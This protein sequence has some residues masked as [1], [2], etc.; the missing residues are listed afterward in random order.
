MVV[1]GGSLAA[2]IHLK[3]IPSSRVDRRRS[4]WRNDLR[5]PSL[6]GTPSRWPVLNLDPPNGYSWVSG[7]FL[8]VCLRWRR[9]EAGRS[10]RLFPA[11]L[12]LCP[13]GLVVR[14]LLGV[15]GRPRRIGRPTP[16]FGV[17]ED[18]GD[19]RETSRNPHPADAL[20]CG[21]R[22]CRRHSRPPGR[23][24][25]HPGRR[26]A[27]AGCVPRHGPTPPGSIR[28]GASPTPSAIW[29]R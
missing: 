13:L 18:H 9:D 4:R 26:R 19:G 28:P 3:Q 27:R 11:V 10:A 17:V 12:R 2:R 15:V 20:L 1:R 6:G 8:V 16:R 23:H 5:V 25:R 22:V 21:R 24:H 7:T 14:S 29:P